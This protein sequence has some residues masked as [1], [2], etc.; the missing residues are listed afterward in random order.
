MKRLKDPVHGYI[1]IED[2]FFDQIIDTRPFQ[3]LR[4]LKQLSAT[5][6]VYPSANHTRFEHSL[7]V[8]SL[9]KRAFDNLRENREFRN[10]IDCDEVETTLLCAA[11]LHDIGHPPFSH[12]AEEL[13]DKSLLKSKLAT[14]GLKK[15][16]D[17]AGIGSVLTDNHPLDQKAEHELLSCIITLRY[18][19]SAIE[20]MGVDP[21]EVAAYILGYSIRAEQNEGWQHR[22]TSHILSST[23]DVDRLD[24]VRRDNFMTGADVA[25]IDTERLVSSYTTHQNSDTGD[26]ELTFSDN[27]LS[28]V[29]NYLEGRLA[30]Y[31]WVT[32][33]HKSVYANALLRELLTELDEYNR[34]DLFTPENVLD[35]YLS[36]SD[37]RTRLRRARD[38]DENERLSRLYDRFFERDFLT[39][40][41]KHKLGYQNKI[42]IDAR[43]AFEDKLGDN[44]TQLEKR[45]AEAISIDDRFVWVEQ[46]YVPNYKPADLRDVQVAYEGEVQSVSDIGLYKEDDYTGP[47]PYI[48]AP[49]GHSHEIVDLLNDALG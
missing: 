49:K 40:C 5:F 6:M 9:A 26:Y 25:N 14:L 47:T 2:K 20:E 37:V 22:V 21:Y 13:L 48:F 4:D 36:D 29:S 1:Q 35:K 41:W 23:M 30:V 33:H 8:F 16:M 32:Q 34:G 39:S 46:S 10:G 12:I 38:A 28:T 11:L 18:Y 7:G 43:E 3:R 45:I 19:T 31:M 44:E 15:R 24:Y 17:E 42:S 27:A